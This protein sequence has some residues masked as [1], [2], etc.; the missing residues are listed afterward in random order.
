MLAVLINSISSWLH[1]HIADDILLITVVY[2]IIYCTFIPMSLL[3][4]NIITV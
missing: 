4:Y 3:T 2:I 1:E